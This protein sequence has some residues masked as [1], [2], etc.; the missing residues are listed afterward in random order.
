VEK[1]RPVVIVVDTNVISYRWM[2]SPYSEAA[3]KAWATDPD[4]I[5]PLLWRSEFRNVLAGAL[6]RKLIALDT[7][8]EI[9]EKAE[10]QFAG[11]EFPV[12][13]RAVMRL[14]VN[15]RCSAYDCEFIALARDQSVPLLTVD[16][17]LLRDFPK[18]AISMEKFARR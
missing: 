10:M 16:R 14:V 7:A 1:T 15:S 12:S 17:Q 18:T 6:R 13:S 5:A 3:D 8:I 11:R 9:V 2:R 4:W